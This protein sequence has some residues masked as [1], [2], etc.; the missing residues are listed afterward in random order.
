M[1]LVWGVYLVSGVSGQRG[2][3][4]QGGFWSGGGLALGG[5]YPQIFFLLFSLNF[6]FEFFFDFFLISLG[7]PPPRKQTQAYG[8]RAAGTHPTG[9]HSCLA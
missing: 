1:Y 5:C 8:Q 9:M 4:G 2:V 3:S 7:I 6:F